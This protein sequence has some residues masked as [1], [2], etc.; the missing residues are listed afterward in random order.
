MSIPPGQTLSIPAHSRDLFKDLVTL[1]QEASR[2]ETLAMAGSLVRQ[3]EGVVASDLQQ[4]AAAQVLRRLRTVDDSD[5]ANLTIEGDVARI[6]SRDPVVRVNSTSMGARFRVQPDHAGSPVLVEL[7]DGRFVPVVPYYGL[8]AVITPTATG[9]VFQAYGRTGERQSY[10]DAIRSIADF[11]AGRLGADSIQQLAAKLR[12][13]KHADPALGAICAHLYRLVGD[14]DNIRRMAYY[15]AFN[16]QPVP[17]DIA[18]LGQMK[19]TVHECNALMLHVP[20]VK[21]RELR[22]DVAGLPDFANQATGAVQCWIA[23]R[24]PWFGLG[25]DHIHQPRPELASLVEGL[26]QFA[27]GARRSGATVLASEVGLRLAGRWALRPAE[28]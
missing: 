1:R 10:R 13:E 22:A 6:W 16:A 11:A 25:W 18:L 5:E 28:V 26:D 4:Q 24:C 2:P 12:H 14:Y 21:A 8:F 3:L 15:F 23:G 27:G 9:D 7:L 20:A 19:V 17:F